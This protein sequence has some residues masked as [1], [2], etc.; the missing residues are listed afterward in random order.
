MK[1]ETTSAR[2]QLAKSL[3][4]A[5]QIALSVAMNPDSKPDVAE[6]SFDSVRTTV[7]KCIQETA[8]L[9]SLGCN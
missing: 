7:G 5:L 2:I 1:C 8:K 4:E 3:P 6:Q 9:P